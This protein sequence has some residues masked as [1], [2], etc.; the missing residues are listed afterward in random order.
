MREEMWL[1]AFLFYSP[2]LISSQWFLS[3]NF[4]S[5]Y[6]KLSSPPP[7]QGKRHSESGRARCRRRYSKPPWQ[8]TPEGVWFCAFL[9]RGPHTH[10]EQWWRTYWRR[11][12]PQW[13]WDLDHQPQNRDR[14]PAVG[15]ENKITVFPLH[16]LSVNLTCSLQAH[17]ALTS[18]TDSSISGALEPKAIRV[19]LETVSFQILTVAVV[20]SPFDFFMVISFSWEV[21][22]W[23]GEGVKKEIILDLLVLYRL[24][25]SGL[26]S[27]TYSAI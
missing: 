7:L 24:P 3:L 26:I 23:S 11:R 2:P 10:T 8:K 1:K 13:C 15:G 9:H 17:V 12:C 6:I 18:I 14:T 27:V 19:R 25:I 16:S 22:T 4:S 20:V 21:I 5:F